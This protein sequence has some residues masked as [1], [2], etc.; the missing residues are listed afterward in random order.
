M[1]VRLEAFA[2]CRDYLGT[3]RVRFRVLL[4]SAIDHC[5]ALHVHHLLGAHSLSLELV[6]VHQIFIHL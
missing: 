3:V 1:G 5:L 2:A 4:G 6:H